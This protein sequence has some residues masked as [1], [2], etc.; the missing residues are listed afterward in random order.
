[1]GRATGL[2]RLVCVFGLG[3]EIGLGRYDGFRLSDMRD[4]RGGGHGT[5]YFEIPELLC[6]LS[7]EDA[8]AVLRS[9]ALPKCGCPSCAGASSV[10]EQIAGTAAHNA[11]IA[12]EERDALAGMTQ[13]ARVAEL[14]ERIA[15]ALA[16]EARLRRMG[17][18]SHTLPHLR[19]WPKVLG[20]AVEMG[21]L[22]DRPLLR[23]LSA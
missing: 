5:P 17:A 23:R 2:R 19:L 21:M 16:A 14:R 10:E 20:R 8:L 15:G 13:D 1:M 7:Q 11:A 18:L 9:S 12:I 22:D 6:S 3:V 4:A